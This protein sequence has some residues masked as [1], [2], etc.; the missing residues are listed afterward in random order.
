MNVFC[1]PS[2][3]MQAPSSKMTLSRGTCAF[4]PPSLALSRKSSGPRMTTAASNRSRFF[5]NVLSGISLLRKKPSVQGVTEKER[6]RLSR[7]ASAM[8]TSL[9]EEKMTSDGYSGIRAIEHSRFFYLSRHITQRS[10]RRRDRKAREEDLA[11]FASITWIR[12]NGSAASQRRPLSHRSLHLERNRTGSPVIWQQ[13]GGGGL[14]S[15]ITPRDGLA[16]GA[17]E[18]VLGKIM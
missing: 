1:V 16:S 8:G 14:M 5:K 6:E 12:F 3:D 18:V 2:R 13:C 4:S 10:K 9:L 17:E 7:I 15:R 11:P